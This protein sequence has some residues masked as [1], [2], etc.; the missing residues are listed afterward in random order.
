MSEHL[1]MA[2]LRQDPFQ[3]GVS[4]A[5][6][7]NR[8]PVC[9]TPPILRTAWRLHLG[10]EARGQKHHDDLWPGER[11]LTLPNSDTTVCCFFQPLRN[12]INIGLIL[13]QVNFMSVTQ[14]W[15]WSIQN[16]V[17]DQ[18]HMT[19]KHFN[20][21]LKQAYIEQYGRVNQKRKTWIVNAGSRFCLPI[22]QFLSAGLSEP[23]CV[24]NIYSIGLHCAHYPQRISTKVCAPNLTILNQEISPTPSETTT[25][26][27]L[28]KFMLLRTKESI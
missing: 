19:V 24:I 12:T 20:N 9:L 26:C 11:T 10:K 1:K 22:F 17:V 23:H 27:T 28:H 5:V 21:C 6:S 8:Y 25:T 3:S 14:F 2:T 16:I 13:Q 15:N 7:V 18:S 4:L